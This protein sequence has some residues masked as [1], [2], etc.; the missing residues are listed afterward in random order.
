VETGT[1]GPALAQ[2]NAALPWLLLAG[3]G[4]LNLG[5]VAGYLIARRRA[6]DSHSGVARSR[7]S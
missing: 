5:G 2:T 7:R 3:P 6:V 1:S 4:L